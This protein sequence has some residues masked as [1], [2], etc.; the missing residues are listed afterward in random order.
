MILKQGGQRFLKSKFKN[1]S[2]LFKNMSNVE[3]II[4]IDF[5]KKG[6]ISK[7]IITFLTVQKIFCRNSRK[8][9]WL[10]FFSFFFF[11]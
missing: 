11:F 6:L 8:R 4:T 9:T 1:M 10:C 2:I 3:N 5:L 7:P